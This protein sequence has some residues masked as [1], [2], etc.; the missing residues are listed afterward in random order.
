MVYSS[1]YHEDEP[2]KFGHLTPGLPSD[3]LREALGLRKDE[4]PKY[5]YLMRELG[6]PPGWLK[7]AEIQSS[8]ISL[9]HEGRKMT[10]GEE[11]E[12][13]ESNSHQSIQV[14]AVCLLIG[15]LIIN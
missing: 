1:R 11:G 10:G 6:Y 7:H 3:K 12:V 13:E 9:Y 8:G 15:Q 14:G 4:A 5:I 2:Q